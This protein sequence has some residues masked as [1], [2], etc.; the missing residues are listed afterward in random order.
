MT[1]RIRLLGA[2]EVSVDGVTHTEQAWSRRQAASLVK[3]LAL[4]PRG[5]LH[6]EQLIDRLWPHLH[7]E[8]A[9]PRLHKAAHYARRVLGE[10]SV[11]LDRETV[12]LFPEDP[13]VA[14]VHEFTERATAAVAATAPE[15]AAEAADLYRGE[16]LPDD[17]Y[18]EWLEDE[19]ERLTRLYVEVLRAAGRWEAILA[20]DPADEEAHLTLAHRLARA[21]DRNGALRQF[22]RLERA[23]RQELGVGLSPTAQ[24][25]RERV[26]RMPAPAAPPGPERRTGPVVVGRDAQTARTRALL[27]EVRDGRGR[28]L[29]V[30]GPPGIGKT[31]LLVHLERQAEQLGMRVG[32][33]TAAATAGDWPFAPVLEAL[34]DL[35][36]RHP[37][38]L[39]GL[40]D[41]MRQ[42]IERALA[43]RATPWAG[44]NTHQRLF[45]AAAELLRL[46]AAGP[47]ALLVVDDV[48]LADDASLKLLHYLA[49]STSAEHV[50][51]AFGHRF[52]PAPALARLRNALLGRSAA[53]TIDLPPLDLDA[54]TALVR[55]RLP[56][57]PDELVAAWHAAT[58]GSPFELA[59]L[60]RAV[61]RGEEASPSTLIP[62]D[63]PGHV[64]EALSDAA[65]LGMRFD[66]DELQA[67]TGG[68]DEDTFALVET[69]LQHRILDRTPGGLR[70]RH[71][72]LRKALLDRLGPARLPVAHAHARAAQALESLGR[73]PAR[74]GRHLVEAKDPVAAVPHLLRAAETQAALGAY[75]DALAT[76]S[77]ARE[78]ATGEHLARLL[79]LRADLLL[80]KGDRSARDAFRAA[81]AVVTDG[82]TRAHLRVG[83]ARTATFAADYET[84]RIALE[85]LEPDG[86][87]SDAEL[88]LAQGLLAYLTGDLA[89]ADSVVAEARRRLAFGGGGAAVMFELVALQGLLAHHRGEWFQ[90]LDSE[91]H[92]AAEDPGASIGLFDS[93]LCA[94]EYMLYGTRPHSEVMELAAELR[95]SAE[96]AGV[97]R[98][99]A[100]ATAL[101]GEAA[102][103]MGNLD[104]AAEELRESADLHHDLG[105]TAGEAHAL[106]RLG[107][108]HLEL[109]EREQATVLATR[110]LPLARWS[111]MA[112]HL[113]QRIY[114]TLV[115][116][117]PTPEE[118]L[119]VVDRA[120]A[121]MGV[122]DECLF[123][124]IMFVVPAGHA[125]AAVGEIERSRGYLDTARMMADRWEGTVWH[126]MVLE[127]QA[128]LER[129]QGRDDVARTL[130]ARAAETFAGAGHMLDAAR[131]RRGGRGGLLVQTAPPAGVGG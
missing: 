99:V 97:L 69:G 6:R 1:V 92:K 62:P 105:S 78:H 10:G 123:C 15:L 100:F 42:E 12:S 127:L 57:A 26:L 64:V 94:A 14:D 126:A 118:A 73:S 58:G 124:Q 56:D 102:L 112:L 115:Y 46:A 98:A 121:A 41:G 130:L 39:D 91:L 60:V 83:L 129:A 119:A 43:G 71:P 106:Q 109:G 72:L 117:A 37:A 122:D 5:R 18:V 74:V 84:A 3:A 76:V 17:R 25:L 53:V 116:A 79:A 31:T 21:G 81:L 108:I 19:R 38:L 110:A 30:A 65:V 128:H 35:S 68:S 32:T 40:D 4:A 20:V 50:L 77:T 104:L 16:L 125:A 27:Q 24:A 67:L 86:G 22:E 47:G 33:A 29:F 96:R 7:P 111:T 107:D 49:R 103:L 55:A 85:G 28:T 34:A 23:L 61:E 90:Q 120:E 8:T 63:L 95:A 87:P 101:R 66:T 13:P 2:F 131:C 88:M 11:V 80:A 36:R 51:L 75:T 52:P 113:L 44:A 59:E 89:T 9:A 45:V 48:G 82:P 54:A 93:Y 70:F 114:G